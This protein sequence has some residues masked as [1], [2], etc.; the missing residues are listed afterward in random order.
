MSEDFLRLVSQANPSTRPPWSRQQQYQPANNGN[1][2]PNRSDALMDPFF[3]DHDD[4]E[5]VPDSAF[6]PIPIQGPT[7]SQESHLPLSRN[8]APPAGRGGLESGSEPGSGSHSQAFP[9]G[10]NF[11]DDD[12]ISSNSQTFPGSSNYPPPPPP[13]KPK[14]EKLITRLRKHKWNW[15]WGKEIMLKGERAI[16]LNNR[17]ANG[18]FCSN[19]V[20]TSKY[21]LVTFLPKFLFGR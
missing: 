6:G 1:G 8:A 17:S 4:E 12:F 15:P 2:Y 16:A 11:D 5:N 3:D 7:R 14:S 10:W 21:N 20:S 19:H 18:E 13:K 9:P